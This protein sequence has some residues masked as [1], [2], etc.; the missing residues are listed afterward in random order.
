MTSAGLDPQRRR[1][2][3]QLVGNFHMVYVDADP[4]GHE[5]NS[6]LLRIHFRQYPAEFL[7]PEKHIIWPAQVGNNPGLLQ[8]S[9]PDGKTRNHRDQRSM[10]RRN[11]RPQKDG[12][13]DAICFFRMPGMPAAS[14]PS[15]LFLR[16]DESSVG[17]TLL[18]KP[19][20]DGVGRI[21]FEKMVDALADRAL[22][23][24]LAKEL[25]HEHV[26]H[27]LDLIPVPGMPFHANAQAAKFFDPAPH[28]EARHADF[29]RD[30]RSADHNQGVVGEQRQERVD[31]AV[32][33][34]SWSRLRHNGS[35]MLWKPQ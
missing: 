31:A 21:R 25:R 22:M 23:Q 30:L 18:P 20:G 19:H 16:D 6:V 27:L 9:V 33:R 7:P 11:G 32:G 8:D 17:L 2:R 4:Y 10:L 1:N 26:R 3:R 29:S 34:S 28:G 12:H 5:M 24:T 14:A 15:R 13:I 35:E